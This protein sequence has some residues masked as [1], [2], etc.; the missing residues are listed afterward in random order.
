MPISP[1]NKRPRIVISTGDPAG[2]GAEITLKA[3]S[4]SKLR[5]KADF[6]ISSDSCVMRDAARLLGISPAADNMPKAGL[7]APSRS[8]FLLD[9]GILKDKKILYGRM[10]KK[11]GRAS[12]KYL[13]NAARLAL[14]G[15]AD[16]LVTAP[17]NKQCAK[18]AG[19]GF[20]GHTE[21]LANL[22]KKKRYVMMLAGGNLRVAL[23]TRHIALK[24]VSGS[25]TKDGIMNTVR[26][27]YGELKSKFGIKRPRIAVCA[28]NPHAGESDMMGDEERRIIG[29]A[30]RQ[31]RK[32]INNIHGPLPADAAFYSGYRK[33]F[34]A[35]ICMYHDQGLIPLKMIARDT[36][37]NITLGIPII[38]T[39]P[40]HGTAYDIAGSSAA[41]ESSM[42]EA[43]NIA[44]GLS[45]N[46]S[47]R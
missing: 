37:V 2:I 13:E 44:V 36:G 7:I 3:L 16:A 32:T 22:C 35:L 45:L 30:V 33:K 4:D 15:K 40:D 24:K 17:I 10:Y 29:P 46:A 11:Y 27:T 21:Y 26:I 14:E 8:P 5:K 18:R 38:R 6:I 9:A 39:S 34:D 47:R 19:F 23:V 28:L 31:L 41:D 12:V 42:K 1:S 25:L 20:L 43:I